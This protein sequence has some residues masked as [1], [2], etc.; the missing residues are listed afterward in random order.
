MLFPS[1][2]NRVSPLEGVSRVNSK[3]FLAHR[4]N[5]DVRATTSNFGLSAHH[6]APC[7]TDANP[8]DINA[9]PRHKLLLVLRK[10]V[11]F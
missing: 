10:R 11:D 4:C 8:C 6:P 9:T 2:I 5:H 3:A 7:T 1:R